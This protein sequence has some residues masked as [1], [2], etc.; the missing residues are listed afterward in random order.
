MCLI[1]HILECR[2]VVVR[3]RS[4]GRVGEERRRVQE[5]HVGLDCGLV[6]VMGLGLITCGEGEDVVGVH[7]L[8][9]GVVQVCHCFGE[10]EEKEEEQGRQEEKEVK[11]RRSKRRD[12]TREH[13]Y[14]DGTNGENL[15]HG[16]CV[17]M[18]SR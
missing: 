17:W 4:R 11:R 18:K 3:V 15:S 1:E 5:L 10:E 7:T 12:R 8:L 14:G 13:G 2:V 16:A 9:S 6:E